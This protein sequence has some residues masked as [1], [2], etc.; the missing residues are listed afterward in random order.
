MVDKIVNNK[1]CLGCGLCSSVLG[2]DNCEM[3]LDESGF[4]KPLL[5]TKIDDKIIGKLCPSIRIKCKGNVL[6]WGS[7]IDVVEGW[8][9]DNDIRFKSASGG[10]VTGLA[11]FLLETHQ[12][13]AIMQV[14]VKE[15]SYLY[16]EMKISHNRK[17]ILNNA[18][19]RY[20]PALT[21]INI[22]EYLHTTSYKFAFIGKP[23]DIAGVKNL[24]SLFP[25][26]EDRFVIFISIFCAGMPSYNATIRAWK[27]SGITT[28]PIKLKYRGYGW[29][30][31]FEVKWED[32]KS[33]K[34]SYTESWGRILGRNV[35]MRCKICPDGIGL[36]ADVS[37]GDSWNTKD[38]YP[39]FS[40]VDGKNFVFV[41]TNKAND[42]II[43][44]QLKGYIKCHSID[45]SK[46]REMQPYQY[47]RRLSVGWRI[48]PIFLLTK[49]LLSFQGLGLIKLSFKIKLMNGIRIAYGSF[50]RFLEQKK[51]N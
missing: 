15:G 8:S 10:F 50:I 47:N 20:A 37:V 33:F 4:Y 35:G 49:G 40:E 18:Q 23:C 34:L 5:K 29:P 3:I 30:G 27:M 41:R 44:A 12:V 22:L 11:L 7:A 1:L 16:N 39:D 9:C 32:G 17:D 42:L 45:Y 6:V 51:Q 31:E 2:K 14:G 24:I 48:L 36:L 43:R 25:Q 13:D 21:L 26:F 28:P 19:S 38:G 46:I